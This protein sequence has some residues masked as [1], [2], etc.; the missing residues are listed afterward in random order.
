MSA[1]EFSQVIVVKG[2]SAFVI[3]FS[4]LAVERKIKSSTQDKENIFFDNFIRTSVLFDMNLLYN[5][6]EG[7]EMSKFSKI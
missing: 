5:R 2:H 4:Q 1:N 6:C 7:N 3:F